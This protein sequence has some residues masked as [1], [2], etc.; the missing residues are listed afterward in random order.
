MKKR[1]WPIATASLFVLGLMSN[2]GC[3]A[4]GSSQGGGGCMGGGM[5]PQPANC[6]PGTVDR[7][8]GCVPY[9]RKGGGQQSGGG[10]QRCP[11]N[12]EEVGGRCQAKGIPATS[13]QPAGQ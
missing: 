6:G 2:L 13:P 1:I 3:P 11:S 4:A 7:G 8:K 5:P 10:G 12:M 9:E